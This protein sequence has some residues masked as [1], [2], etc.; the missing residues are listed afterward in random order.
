MHHLPLRQC[1]SSFLVGPRPKTN[2]LWKRV[3]AYRYVYL[4]LFPGFAF[5]IIFAYVP[6]YGIQ[7]AF[8]E[9]NIAKGFFGSPW[10]GFAKLKLLVEYPEFWAAFRSTIVIAL[11][12]ILFGFPAPILIAILLNELRGRRSKKI[13][14]TVYT[15]PHFLS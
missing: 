3:F 2:T 5:F 10:V 4:I 15:F 1:A 9:Y 7:L 8:K 12:K 6:M 13:L 14:Q 11:L